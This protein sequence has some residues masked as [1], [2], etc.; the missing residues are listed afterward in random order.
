MRIIL[1]I[2]LFPLTLALSLFVAICRFVCCMS[3]ALLSVLSSIMF[4]IALLA[5]LIPS[6]NMP[7]QTSIIVWIVAFLISPFGIPMFADWLLDKLEDLNF[8]IRAI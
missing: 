5:L 2:L 6:I 7:F 1:K 3:G 4:T 8:A